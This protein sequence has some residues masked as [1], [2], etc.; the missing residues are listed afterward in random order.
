MD[1][2]LSPQ[3]IA[4]LKKDAMRGQIVQQDYE[5]I[6]AKAQLAKT[7]KDWVGWIE[8]QDC[9]TCQSECGGTSSTDKFTYTCGYWVER[10]RSIGL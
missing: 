5:V 9:S 10:K 3:E 4:K 6:I 1:R 7:D 2:L 8:K